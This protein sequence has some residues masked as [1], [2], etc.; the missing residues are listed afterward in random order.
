MLGSRDLE[1][2]VIRS[3]DFKGKCSELDICKEKLSQVAV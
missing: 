2:I 3:K 1:R